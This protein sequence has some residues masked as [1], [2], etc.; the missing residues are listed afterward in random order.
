MINQYFYVCISAEKRPI[1]TPNVAPPLSKKFKETVGHN[2]IVHQ[3]KRNLISR[4]SPTTSMTS[5]M[6]KT[7]SKISENADENGQV[8]LGNSLHQITDNNVQASIR[9]FDVESYKKYLSE[10]M[11]PTPSTNLEI[12]KPVRIADEKMFKEYVSKHKETK[13]YR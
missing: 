3:P 11:P 5:S 2:E 12:Q 8:K 9:V 13:E 7:M 4:K 1:I 10:N 6:S